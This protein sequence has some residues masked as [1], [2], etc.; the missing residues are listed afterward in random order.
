M[1][2]KER[3]FYENQGNLILEGKLIVEPNNDDVR[4]MLLEIFNQIGAGL[5]L[6]IGIGPKPIVD[7]VLMERGYN[8]LGTDISHSFTKIA[9][10]MFE[11]KRLNPYLVA[12]EAVNLPFS[13]AVFDFCLCSEVI[14]HL[15]DPIALFKEINRVLRQNGK[16][17][18]TA[19]NKVSLAGAIIGLRQGHNK[20]TAHIREYTGS[21]I[22]KLSRNFFRLKV[23]YY[24]R[25]F[26]MGEYS[27]LEA[28]MAKICNFIVSLP[29][30]NKLGNHIG[31]LFE[32]LP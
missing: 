18:L 6:D 2:S 17:I 10:S 16:L 26:P 23:R 3:E 32:K 8:V 31:F 9:K 12:S 20:N 7:I 28:P 30:L 15:Q 1:P 19:P 5:V 22:I 29:C 27:L 14:E 4:N 24:T 21:Q 11:Q 25:S 13:D